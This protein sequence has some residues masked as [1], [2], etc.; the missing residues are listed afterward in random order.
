MFAGCRA[1]QCWWLDA[2]MLSTCLGL[3]LHMSCAC[4]NS[5]NK[6][7]I[8]FPAAMTHGGRCTLS[9]G[10][11]AFLCLGIVCWGTAHT[12]KLWRELAAWMDQDFG[13]R[14]YMENRVLQPD[15]VFFFFFARYSLWQAEDAAVTSDLFESILEHF[16]PMS[17]MAL[18]WNRTH[19]SCGTCY[20]KAKDCLESSTDVLVASGLRAIW[21]WFTLLVQKTCLCCGP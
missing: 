9:S 12:C 7:L 21:L 6:I 8:R 2:S 19:I 18:S 16:L 4:W 5:G 1:V 15:A 20:T 14:S 10:E 11:R 17:H 3:K 13:T